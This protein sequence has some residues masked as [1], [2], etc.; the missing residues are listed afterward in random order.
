MSV[1]GNV[2][3]MRSPTEPLQVAKDNSAKRAFI[4]IASKRNVLDFSVDIMD[5]VDPIFFSDPRMAAL[6]V[7]GVV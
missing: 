6:K 4:P 5:H 3:P 7:L 2:K 1:Q